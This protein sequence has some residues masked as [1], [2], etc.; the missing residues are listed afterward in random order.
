MASLRDIAGILD[1]MK[2]LALVEVRRIEGYIAAQR[3]AATVVQDALADVMQL[4]GPHPVGGTAQTDVLVVIGAERGFCGDFQARA[5]AGAARVL[6]GYATPVTPVLVGNWTDRPAPLAAAPALAGASV[7]EDVPG[8]LDELVAQIT[9]CMRSPAHPGPPGLR[10]LYRDA[11]GAQDRRVLPLTRPGPETGS[12]H[13]DTLLPDATL[14]G[15][16]TR[17]WAEAMLQTALLE[18][19]LAENHQRLDHMDNAIRTLDDRLADLDR[20]QKRLRQEEITQE[21]ELILLS[22]SLVEAADAD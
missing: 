22:S 13:V 19:L 18:S 1:A 15:A 17:Q 2:N 7:A 9:K 16:L 10:I 6:D 14:A 4:P 3:A 20:R 8:V 5:A 12:R 21:I 11:Q